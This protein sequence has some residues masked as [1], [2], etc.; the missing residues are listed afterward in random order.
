MIASKALRIGVITAAVVGTVAIPATAL[1][2]NSSGV[3]MHTFTGA[4][5][6]VEG[7]ARGSEHFAGPAHGRG[8]APGEAH[9][10]ALAASL[11]VTAD[12]L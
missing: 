3:G 12:A 5:A 2:A 10:T 9:L 8:G 1:A 4:S 7:R 6:N 11:S